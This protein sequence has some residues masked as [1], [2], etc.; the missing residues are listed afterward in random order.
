MAAGIL[1]GWFLHL[2]VQQSYAR[3]NNNKQAPSLIKPVVEK[4]PVVI[5][6]EVKT[7]N[8]EHEVQKAFLQRLC[9]TLNALTDVNQIQSEGC[10]LLGEFLK[11]SRVIYAEVNDDEIIINQDYRNGVS[12]LAGYY[13]KDAFNEKIPVANLNDAAIFETDILSSSKITETEKNDYQAAGIA[14]YVSYAIAKQDKVVASFGVHNAEPR[15]WTKE[16]VALIEETADKIYFA[17][18][19]IKIN[20]AL[21]KSEARLY[22]I[23]QSLNAG[24]AVIDIMGNISLSN[25]EMRRFMPNGIIPSRDKET[26]KRWK[27]FRADGRPIEPKDFPSNRAIRGETVLPGIEMLYIQEDGCEIWTRVA[28]IPIKDNRGFVTEVISVVTDIS[29]EKKLIEA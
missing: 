24:I 13:P 16:E 23:F 11:V 6:K 1:C 26:I 4:T 19:K 20:E 14:A 5:N 18:E 27:A 28:S 22:N 10:R 25:K 29:E 3:K 17:I 7:I 9:N 8:T 12:S 2:F 21:H 15:N